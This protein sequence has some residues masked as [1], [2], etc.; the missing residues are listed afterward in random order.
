MKNKCSTLLLLLCVV[1]HSFSQDSSDSIIFDKIYSHSLNLFV[2]KLENQRDS[3]MLTGN[4]E[5]VSFSKIIGKILKET[6]YVL[7][8]GEFNH[9][10]LDEIPSGL[11]IIDKFELSKKTKF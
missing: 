10:S 7:N 8:Q 4:K 6:K 11:K 1:Y 9:S 3:L 5:D 2:S